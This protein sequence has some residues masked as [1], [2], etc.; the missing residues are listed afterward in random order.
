LYRA[1]PARAIGAARGDEI[2]RQL[3]DVGY[4]P[5]YSPEVIPDAHVLSAHMGNVRIET[6]RAFNEYKYRKIVKN[7]P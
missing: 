6:H 5:R 3:S 2:G 1:N 4:L 7:I